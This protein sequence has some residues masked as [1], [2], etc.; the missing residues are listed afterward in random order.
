MT[1]S[2]YIHAVY[3]AF[4]WVF[5]FLHSVSM[6]NAYS[7]WHYRRSYIFMQALKK[8]YFFLFMND[9]V[10]HSFCFYFLVLQV[11]ESSNRKQTILTL[12]AFD[13][14]WILL[15]SYVADMKC[16]AQLYVLGCERWSSAL[17]LI[18]H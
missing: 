13:I 18:Q 5:F 16:C 6:L 11:F 3:Q 8:S 17:K 15:K 9:F 10:S 4:V 2:V 12:L 7:L 14:Q 1:A